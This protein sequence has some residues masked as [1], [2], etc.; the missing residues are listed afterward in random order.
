[1]ISVLIY[2]VTFFTVAS[3]LHYVYYWG[4]KAID[5]KTHLLEKKQGEY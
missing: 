3:G 2:L 5:Q 4:R 1:L